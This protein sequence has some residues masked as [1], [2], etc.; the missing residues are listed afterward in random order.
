MRP[1][2]KIIAIIPARGG[3]KGLSR[4]NIR[5][6]AEKPL[7]AWTIE[8]AKKSKYLDRIVVSTEDKEIAEVSEK[9]GVEVIKRPAELARD[10]SPTFDA[11]MHVIDY[12]QS[13]G[14]VFDIVV[15]LEATSPLR[16]SED[17]DKCIEILYS[18]EKARAIVSIAKLESSHPEF[19]VVLNKE[20]FIKK[21]NGTSNFRTLRRQELQDIFFFDGTI[22]IS[23]IDTY[24]QKRTIYHELTLG[25]IV[26]KYKS[27]EVD[28]IYDFISIE[29]LIKA[30]KEGKI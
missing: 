1:K 4:K 24:K 6:I 19:N 10:N 13:K 5:I 18:N 27:L 28:D 9:Y 3:S 12:F 21:I 16:D 22:Y 29:A 25:Y 7:I 26:P 23:Y 17:I 2:E 30:K 8:S 20:R 15:I 14:E 11:V